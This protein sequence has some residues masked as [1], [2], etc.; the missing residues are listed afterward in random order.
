MTPQSAP[1]LGIRPRLAG[2][3]CLLAGAAFFT[4]AVIAGTIISSDRISFAAAM[5]LS[6]PFVFGTLVLFNVASVALMLAALPLL[7]DI[8]RPV[9][10]RLARLAVLAGIV[11]CTVQAAA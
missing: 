8:V 11:A 5:M 1:A 7:R 10:E 3:L 9:S 2:R 6:H 4:S